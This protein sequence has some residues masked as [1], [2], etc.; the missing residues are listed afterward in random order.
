MR[1]E[2]IAPGVQSR[3]IGDGILVLKQAVRCK[4]FARELD[5]IVTRL[6]HRRCIHQFELQ[7]SAGVEMNIVL[8]EC[9]HDSS[10]T[11]HPVNMKTEITFNLLSADIRSNCHP[12]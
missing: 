10:L 11:E 3:H 4:P 5:P 9:Y 2:A 1:R 8:G 6:F 12:E 7:G